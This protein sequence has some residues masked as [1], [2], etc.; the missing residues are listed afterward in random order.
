MLEQGGGSTQGPHSSCQPLRASQ[1]TSAA[2]C[3]KDRG[4]DKNAERRVQ[5]IIPSEIGE[6]QVRDESRFDD[7]DV[8]SCL[9]GP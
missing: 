6:L 8:N 4:K 9:C 1:P 5:R 2:G 3:D 7:R